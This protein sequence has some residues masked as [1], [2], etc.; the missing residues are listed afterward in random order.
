M[1]EIL[2]RLEN[3]VGLQPSDMAGQHGCPPQTFPLKAR[4]EDP[5]KG[6]CGEHKWGVLLLLLF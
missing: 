2:V 3:L 5:L 4:S 1:Y 6:I